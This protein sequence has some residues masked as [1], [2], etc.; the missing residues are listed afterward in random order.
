MLQFS[1]SNG[2][3][4]ITELCEHCREHVRDVHISEI[5]YLHPNE[6]R[7]T[8]ISASDGSTHQVKTKAQ[9]IADK[10]ESLIKEGLLNQSQATASRT[11]GKFAY[12]LKPEMMCSQ[13]IDSVLGVSSSFCYRVTNPKF[14]AKYSQSFYT[15]SEDDTTSYGKKV[16]IDKDG[17]LVRLKSEKNFK[18]AESTLVRKHPWSVSWFAALSNAN[19]TDTWTKHMNCP[20]IKNNTLDRYRD[21]AEWLAALTAARSR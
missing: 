7:T 8:V 17:N 4:V 12:G 3:Q 18:T 10:S 5:T 1:S 14:L 2:T 19:Q 6:I 16:G 21:H 9:F 20:A 11:S 13:S 15:A